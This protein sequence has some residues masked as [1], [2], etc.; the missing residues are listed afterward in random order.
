ME[1]GRTNKPAVIIL[2]VEPR[3]VGYAISN[4]L[5]RSP[6][7]REVPAGADLVRGDAG[8]L[9]A[10]QEAEVARGRIPPEAARGERVRVQGGGAGRDRARRRGRSRAGRRFGHRAVGGR[11]GRHRR[12]RAT[13]RSARCW[14][15]TAFPTTRPSSGA[16]H[17]PDAVR[18]REV[19]SRDPG[20]VRGAGGRRGRRVVADQR[21]GRSAQPV[22]RR[23]SAAEPGLGA[24]PGQG[25]DD[26]IRRRRSGQLPHGRDA[27]SRGRRVGVRGARADP[28][29]GRGG[30]ARTGRDRVRRRRDRRVRRGGAGGRFRGRAARE[31]GRGAQ[32]RAGGAHPFA[33]KRAPDAAQGDRGSAGAL[34][35]VR[36]LLQGARV[37]RSA[38]D[39]QQ[40]GKGHPRSARRAGR[41]G[42]ADPRS[43]GQ[44]P[45]AGSRA[46]RSG[47]ELARVRAQPRRRQ[48]AGRG[49][50]AGQPEVRRAR[51]G[52][53]RRGSTTRTRSCARRARRSTG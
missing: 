42:P 2:S 44:D 46:A 31:G 27:G 20:G 22:V 30:S 13:T 3:K 53:S 40:E 25:R 17:G 5:R 52:R 37:P 9:R 28:G 51:E 48:R 21:H 39:H 47:R 18:G 49:A 36:D 34:H 24:G 50:G 11:R 38:R 29:A 15:A 6:S 7:L 43:Q 33:R 45:G 23:R 32:L 41:E 8:D 19:R 10:A 26:Q 14:S 12:R 35:A 1:W 4:K 16:G